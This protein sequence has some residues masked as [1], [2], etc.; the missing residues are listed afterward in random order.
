MGTEDVE[1]SEEGSGMGFFTTGFR[2]GF[3]F[4]GF[5]AYAKRVGERGSKDRR[6]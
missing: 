3:D 2:A 5:T 6:E 4:M 1:A